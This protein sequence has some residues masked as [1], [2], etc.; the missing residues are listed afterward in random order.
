MNYSLVIIDMQVNFPA[1]QNVKTVTAV[2]REINQAKRNNRP[3]FLVEISPGCMPCGPSHPEILAALRGYDNWHRVEKYGSDGTPALTT[4]QAESIGD[5]PAI[6]EIT[7]CKRIRIVGVNTD[8]CVQMTALGLKGSGY[9][10]D[11]V[12][13][14]C[15]S[16]YD[17]TWGLA[18]MQRFGCRMLRSAYA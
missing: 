16:Q 15:H 3:I 17:H 13:D 5:G 7:S 8:C 11:V 12:T 4:P 10:V 14:A 9:N 6:S 18:V 1:A 2:I